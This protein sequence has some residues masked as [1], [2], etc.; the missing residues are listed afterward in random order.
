MVD[1]STVYHDDIFFGSNFSLWP[2]GIDIGQF[3]Y[4][5]GISIFDF[6]VGFKLVFN[7]LKFFDSNPILYHLVGTIHIE[8]NLFSRWT[9]LICLRFDVDQLFIGFKPIVGS[10]DGELFWVDG[11]PLALASTDYLF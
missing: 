1:I 5:F 8:R 11:L 10:V 2:F 6:N 3:D 9:E 7:I 4:R